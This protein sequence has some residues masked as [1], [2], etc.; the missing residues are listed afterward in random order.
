MAMS[1][2]KRK[3]Q[4]ENPDADSGSEDE[5]AMRA[6]FQQAFESKFHPLELSKAR[7]R[8]PE[9][10]PGVEDDLESEESDWSGFADDEDVVEIIDRHT[11][12]SED[13]QLQRHE[14]RAFMV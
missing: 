9:P 3:R 4:E 1:I 14:E 6:R 7:K 2:G 13:Q 10:D 11:K 8:N 12:P 5:G